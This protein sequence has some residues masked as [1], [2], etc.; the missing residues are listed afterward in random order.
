MTAPAATVIAGVS[1]YSD[2]RAFN[3]DRFE[4]ALS[5]DGI[6]I[7]RPGQTT[8]RLSWDHVTEWEIQDRRGGVLLTLRGRGAVTPLLV[9]RWTVDELEVVLR[10]ATAAA[11]GSPE[12]MAAAVSAPARAPAAAPV[13]AAAPEP[14]VAPE[15][16]A[17]PEPAEAPHSVARRARH[18]LPRFERWKVIVTVTLLAVL[19]TAVTL[20]LLQSAG[21]IHLSFL[22][23]TA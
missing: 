15:P 9:P 22:G 11:A 16:T 2:E 23:P 13:P 21:V 6:E 17:A 1:L 4:I 19:A 10:D 8:R 7:R 18:H 5:S 20:V 12:S 3:G 14:K